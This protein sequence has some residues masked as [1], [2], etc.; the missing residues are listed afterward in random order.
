[1]LSLAAF[2]LSGCGGAPPQVSGIVAIADFETTACVPQEKTLQIRNNDTSEPQRVQGVMFE[3]GTNN[4]KFYKILEVSTASNVK[5]VVGNLAEEVLLPPGGV[6]SVKVA[7]NPK[8][9]TAG[10]ERQYTYLDFILNG[11][12]LGVMQIELRG[13]AETA[14]PG[15]SA[16]SG[17]ARVFQVVSLKTILNDKDLTPNPS[18]TDLDVTTQVKGDFKFNIDGE[19]VVLPLDGWPEITLQPPGQAAV[20]VKLDE[21][22]P[23][24]SF[25]GGELKIDDMTLAA[26]GIPVGGVTI[27]TGTVTI[28]AA[29]ADGGSFSLT[30]STFDETSG[31]MTLV[32]ATPLTNAAFSSFPIF[33]GAFGAEIH[34]K[35]KK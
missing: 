31:E 20:P 32:V 16:D 18:E 8:K 15:C 27:T 24:G 9:T 12:K 3:M 10:D 23:E 17:N 19:K 14:A 25:A 21:D 26:S 33:N 7:F 2:A 6:L 22:S 5:K 29:D 35:E 1:M 30:G 4:D 28:S 13:K 34:L 11:P